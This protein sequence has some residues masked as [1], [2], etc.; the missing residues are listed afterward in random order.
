MG[1]ANPARSFRVL[2]HKSSTSVAGGPMGNSSREMTMAG[3]SGKALWPEDATGWAGPAPFEARR[4]GCLRTDRQ[5]ATVLI[6]PSLLLAGLFACTQRRRSRLQGASNGTTPAPRLISSVPWS[7]PRVS[8]LP[9]LWYLYCRQMVE[10]GRRLILRSSSSTPLSAQRP[11]GQNVGPETTSICRPTYM[12]SRAVLALLVRLSS[13]NVER[14]AAL[15]AIGGTHCWAS[16]CFAGLVKFLLGRAPVAYASVTH[17]P[18]GQ[19]RRPRGSW[20]AR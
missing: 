3:S 10:R 1:P 7:F 14:C 19:L 18:I 4:P 15:G 6:L 13:T 2:M 9:S 5:A 17:S 16:L 20:L 11:T 12:L 8:I